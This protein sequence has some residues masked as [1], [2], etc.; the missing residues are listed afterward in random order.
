MMK[1]CPIGNKRANGRCVRNSTHNTVRYYDGEKARVGDLIQS[2][3]AGQCR[4]LKVGIEGDI[5]CKNIHTEK[6]ISGV[7]SRYSD[8]LE[9]KR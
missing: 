7:N 2:G 3:W 6:I 8:L 9:R 5:T 4:V 1:R